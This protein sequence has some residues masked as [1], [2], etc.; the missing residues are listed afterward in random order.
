ML[1]CVQSVHV[2]VDHTD[3]LPHTAEMASLVP[4]P[5]PFFLFFGLRCPCTSVYY[6]Q[7]TEKTEAWERCYEMAV[8]EPIWQWHALIVMNS[9]HHLTTKCGCMIHVLYDKHARLLQGL[10]LEQSIPAAN[11]ASCPFSQNTKR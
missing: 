11:A 8:V 4:R 9:C 10:G 3:C 1:L 7:R 6:C 5:T 2:H